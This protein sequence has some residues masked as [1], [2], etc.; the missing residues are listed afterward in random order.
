MLQLV[1]VVVGMGG[2]SVS[3]IGL[4][5]DIAVG[6]ISETADQAYA[7]SAGS[8]AVQFVVNVG[9]DI[10][11]GPGFAGFAAGQVVT[12]FGQRAGRSVILILQLR[13]S[14]SYWVFQGNTF[15]TC[16]RTYFASV[17]GG[18]SDNYTD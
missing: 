12:E 7:V 11:V 2:G 15:K 17:L 3:G 14:Y 6:V 9:N 8:E 4:S 16:D 18:S 1:Q 5:F 13:P 10:A